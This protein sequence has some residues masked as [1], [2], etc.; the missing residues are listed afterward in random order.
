MKGG[1]GESALFLSWDIGT[2]LL[3]PP[4]TG[5]PGPSEL[6]WDLDHWKAQVHRLG[7]HT[8]TIRSPVSQAFGLG[9]NYTTSL[10]VPQLKDGGR[11][12]CSAFEINS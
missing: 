4:D 2:S 9:Q 10:P 12:D 8:Y 1:A 6:G 5:T 7:T 3:C 11:Q